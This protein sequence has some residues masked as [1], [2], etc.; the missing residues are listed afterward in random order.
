MME[1]WW[2]PRGLVDVFHASGG[3]WDIGFALWGCCFV[4]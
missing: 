2:D 4:G 3:M 1:G